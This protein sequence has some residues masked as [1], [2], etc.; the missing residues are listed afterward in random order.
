M[1]EGAPITGG[2]ARRLQIAPA[3]SRAVLL[4]LAATNPMHTPALS[5]RMNT[6]TTNPVMAHPA[7]PAL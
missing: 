5:P 2:D 6:I 1:V 7:R 4:R 3:Q